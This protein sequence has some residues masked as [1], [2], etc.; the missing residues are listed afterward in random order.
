LKAPACALLFV[1]AL[2]FPGLARGTNVPAGFRDTVA[3]SNLTN[4]TAVRFAPA[5]DTRVF[6]AEQAGRILVYDDLD[7]PTPTVVADLRDRVNSFWDRGLLGL[8]LDPSFPLQPYLYALYT[9]DAMPGAGAPP[10]KWDDACPNPPGATTGGCVVTGRLTRLQIDAGNHWTGSEYELVR[11][12][13]CQQYPSHS[14]ADLAFGPDGGLYA[15]AGDGASWEYGDHGQ[16]GGNPC[17][18][19]VKE[20]GALRAQDYRTP[21][22]PLGYDGSVIRVDRTGATPPQLVAYG[23]RNPFRMTFRPGTDELWIG[24]VGWDAVEE[25]DTFSLADASTP[26]NFG[27]P[28]Y[29][30]TGQPAAYKEQALPICESLYSAPAGAVSW[31]FFSYQHYQPIYPGAPPGCVDGGSSISG[32]AFYHGAS[33]PTLDGAL[34]V[35]DY[36]RNCIWTMQPDAQGVPIPSTASVFETGALTPVDVEIG[37]SGDVYYV[38]FGVPGERA[39]AIHRIRYKPPVAVIDADKT[40]GPSPLTVQFDGSRSTAVEPG[41]ALTYDWD[42]GDGSPHSSAVS[43]THTFLTGTRT[44]RLKVTD[45]ANGLTSTASQVISA[46]NVAPTVTITKPASG[47]T[48]RVGDS[49]DFAATAEDSNEALGPSAYS[50]SLVLHHC[51]ASC[52]V[53]PLQDF[54]GVTG[55]SFLAPDHGYPSHL[56]LSVTVTDSGGLTDTKSV[57]LQPATVPLHFVSEPAGLRLVVGG[58]ED[59]A[60]FDREVIVG[61]QNELLAPSPQGGLLFSSWSDLGARTHTITAPATPTTYVATFAAPAPPPP[62]PPPSPPPPPPPAGPKAAKPCV[63]PRLSGLRLAVAG[64]ALRASRCRLGKASWVYSGTARGVIRSQSPRAGRR[65]ANGAKVAVVVSRG[66]RAKSAGR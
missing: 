62:P 43:P 9:Y 21:D 54:P 34:F 59:A 56:E 15:S 23:F 10:G 5:P 4:P 35:S 47:T 14:I 2:A 48:W 60:P 27:W 66:R 57:E 41:G 64:R 51:P 42:F 26:L 30:G 17:G 16:N 45:P 49:I 12:D 58:S 11:Q 1:L 53:H 44:V 18:D 24:D 22:D 50:W 31:P 39:G 8:A 33:Y 37:P 61:S 36:A 28:C 38:D 6:V 55:G 7:D 25:I 63:V 32:L 29:E 3:I 52:H 20:G 65:L 46:D 40:E 13:W 19:P